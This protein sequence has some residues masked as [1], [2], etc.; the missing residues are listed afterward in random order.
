MK[1]TYKPEIEGLRILSVICILFYHAEFIF[2]GKNFF[3]GGFIGVDFF[4]VISGYLITSLIL[5]E[6]NLTGNF[7]FKN[8][9]ERRARRILPVLIFVMLVS[10]P[11]AW[12]YLLPSSMVDYAKSLLYSLGFTSNFYYSLDTPFRPF[13][14]TWSL[15]ILVQFYVFFPIF[16]LFIFKYLKDYIFS[17]FIFLVLISIFFSFTNFDK[18]NF[19]TF[20]KL[21]LFL[22]GSILY[23]KENTLITISK[24]IVIN[25]FLLI[26]SFFTIIIFIVFYNNQFQYNNIFYFLTLTFFLYMFLQI[27]NN[28]FIFKILS[29]RILVGL[30]ALSL[31]LYL[32]HYP[33]FIFSKIIEFTDGDII[34]KIF[35]VLLIIALSITSYFLIEK[36]F[37]KIKKIRFTF[38]ISLSLILISLLSFAIIKNNGFDN[39]MPNFLIKSFNSKPNYNRLSQLGKTCFGRVLDFCNFNKTSNKRV[40]L[41]G[42]SHMGSLIYSLKNSLVKKNYNFI[43]ITKG[44]FIYLPNTETLNFSTRKKNLDYEVINKNISKLLINSDDQIIIIGGMLSLYIYEKRFLKNDEVV[45]GVFGSIYVENEDKIHNSNFL[46]IEFKKLL[47]NLLKKNKVILIYPIPNTDIDVKKKLLKIF[48][49]KKKLDKNEYLITTDYM[50]YL[51]V[52]KDVYKLLDEI[53][54][55]NLYRVYP[56]KIFCNNQIKKRCITHNKNDI[57]FENSWHPSLKGS[58]M[59]N[60]LILDK[61]EIIEKN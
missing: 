47:S 19:Y 35:L 3:Q 18:N 15:S 54:N 41:I 17:I 38:I 33:I 42:D 9:Y 55:P 29:S 28:N 39:R 59:I 5:K 6:L 2:F 44:G 4:F 30:G 31:S 14:H 50:N 21:G 37:M 23:Y 61:I 32:W 56:E 51:K 40:I 60:N 25:N 24:N 26:V 45:R 57:F 12:K 13:L 11:F 58:Q 48:N 22:A 20:S 27:K 53:N 46:E 8:F 1:L 16:L 43:P 36:P 34:K 49:L 10:I 7:S 52:N